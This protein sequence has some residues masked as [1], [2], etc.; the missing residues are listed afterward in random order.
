MIS[1]DALCLAFAIPTGPATTAS[2]PLRPP[3]DDH[4][5]RRDVSGHPGTDN[6][7]QIL[8]RVILKLDPEPR[9]NP[10]DAHQSSRAPRAMFAPSDSPYL[11]SCSWVWTLP[12]AKPD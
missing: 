1:I 3:R 5:V 4:V 10:Q 12:D 8:A 7:H 9:R 11:V 2:G 6:A